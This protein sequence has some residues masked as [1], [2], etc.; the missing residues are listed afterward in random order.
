MGQQGPKHVT[1]CVLKHYCDSLELCVFAGRMIVVS[2]VLISIS[3][4]RILRILIQTVP[5]DDEHLLLETCRG[6]K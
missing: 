2:A 6:V 1:V 3:G 4:K 5:P